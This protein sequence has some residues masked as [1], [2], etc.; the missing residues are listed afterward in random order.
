MVMSLSRS[1]R[2]QRRENE[3]DTAAR[4]GH[5][6]IFVRDLLHLAEDNVGLFDFLHDFRCF[7]FDLLQGGDYSTET[8]ST[9]LRAGCR[10]TCHCRE[11]CLR[12]RSA[13]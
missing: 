5:G 6:Q 7:R 13:L 2:G 3:E 1:H 8:M 11:S 10:P 12:I 4:F 9:V